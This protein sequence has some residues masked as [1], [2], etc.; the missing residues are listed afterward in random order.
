MESDARTNGGLKFPIL[1][2]IPDLNNIKSFTERYFSKRYVLN[3]NGIKNNDV[4]ILFHSN[5]IALL[6]LAPSH[7]FF[8]KDEEY[9]I[10]FCVG[11][12]NR[13]ANSVK[14]KGKKGGQHLIPNS[15]IGKVEYKD[16]TSFDILCCMSGTLVE[17]NEELV[18]SPCL[19]KSYPDSN[20]FIAIVL[21]S[22]KIADNTKNKMLTHEEYTEIIKD[23]CES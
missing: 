3:V 11:K 12:L 15:V 22:I 1:D 13:L 19:L 14:G 17:I 21:S 4:M 23:C 6:S 2:S 5:R 18:K 16:G 20:G 10:N 9:K 8:K 7:F